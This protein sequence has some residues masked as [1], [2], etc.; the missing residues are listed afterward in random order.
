MGQQGWAMYFHRSD[1]VPGATYYWRID[2]VAADGKVYTGDVWS[3]TAAPLVAYSPDPADGAKYVATD[4][5][6]SWIAGITA[7]KHDVYFGTSSPPAFIGNQFGTTYDPAGLLQGA[8][9]YWRIDEVEA[10]DTVKHEGAVWSFTTM[11]DI[12]ISDPNLIGW[13]KLDGGSGSVALD[14]SGL[15]NDGDIVGSPLWVEGYMDSALELTGSDYIAVDAVNDDITSNSISLSVWVKTTDTGAYLVASNDDASASALRFG[16]QNGNAYVRDDGTDEGH[17]DTTVSDDEWHM[18]TYVRTGST[19]YIYVDGYLEGTHSADFDLTTD[20]RWSIGQEWDGTTPSD[21]YIGAVDDVRFYRAA[22]TQD[23]IKELMRVDPLL[24]WDASPANKS[25]PDI[26]QASVLSWRPGDEAV[27]HDVY[28]GTDPAAVASADITTAGIYRGRQSPTVYIAP[29]ALELGRTYYWRI[30]ENNNDATVSTGEVWSFTVAMHLTVDDF[31]D[32]NDFSPDRVFQTWID[33]FGY[34]DPPPGRLGNGTNSTVGYL[35]A[36]FAEQTTVHGGG[37][38]MPFGYDNT[39]LPFYSETGREFLVAQN[40]MRK[41][42]TSLSLWVYG[43]PNSAPAH[44]YIGLQDSTGIRRDVTDTITSRVRTTSWQEVYFDL[45]KF[46]PVNLMSVKKMYIGVGNRLSPSVGGA[47]DIF[48]DDIRLYGPRCVASL[49][50]PANDLNDDCVVDYLDVEI[51]SDDWLLSDV[52]ESVWDGPFTNADIGVPSAAG[53]YSFD[54]TTYTVTGN[55]HDIW[56][57]ADDFQ[58]AYRQ[59]S[60]DC[61]MTV[62]VKSMQ[63]VHAWAKAGVMIRDTLDADSSNAMIALTG[64]DGDGGTFQWRS[65]ADPN[66]NSSRTLTGISPPACVRLV[67]E[68]DTFTGYIFLD[69][70]WQQEGVATTVAMTDPVYIGLAVTSHTDGVLE[71]ATFDRECTFSVAELNA[72]GV[73]DFKDYAALADT[74]LDEA[75]WPAP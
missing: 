73:I 59:I 67:R 54:G 48:V 56:D 16:I 64:G 32:Y 44:L 3:F 66:S 33:G 34:T 47:G 35:A 55:G 27:Q 18:L 21:F 11:P 62:R 12:P 49:L 19:G 7:I 37:Q 6:L 50:K 42:V 29:A 36:P 17:S 10:G 43:D 39:A 4:T 69:G 28:F 70:R 26:E 5:V 30:D 61:Q 31:E 51:L 24:A 52:A 40:F 58:Y 72:D 71:T 1:L 60:G 14:W 46:A 65:Q 63:Q 8:T 2:E 9:Y 45:S 38:S 25:V 57:D 53:S 41:G 68:G 23:Q 22:L 13:W 15:G 20:D 74:W 75:L